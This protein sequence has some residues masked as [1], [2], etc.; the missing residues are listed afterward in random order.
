[1]LKKLLLALLL[2]AALLGAVV[3]LGGGWLLGS[4]TRA[5][6]PHLIDLAERTGLRVA[7]CEFAGTAVRPAARLSW[8]DWHIGLVRP[9]GGNRAAS[10]AT[11]RL[12]LGAVRLVCTDWAPLTAD[13]SVEG[14]VLETPFIPAAPADL[15]FA[16]DEFGVAIDRIDD[17]FLTIPEVVLG[18]DPR[19]ALAALA[20][21]LEQLAREG[22]TTRN[23]NLGARLHFQIGGRPLSVRLETARRSGATWLEFNAA[24]IAELS[25][26]H[27]RPLTAAEQRILCE[28]PQRALLLLR[29]KE[30]AERLAQRLARSDR[31]YGEDFTRHVVWSY[32]LTRTFGADFAQQVTDAHEAGAT[33]NTEAQH[34]QDF[35]NNTVGRSYALAKKSEGQVLRLI[36]T[37]PQIVRVAQ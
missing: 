1:V 30:Y 12:R 9:A 22:R 6:L 15:P 4:A 19:R 14:G 11:L 7:H 21:D 5:A 20:R 25:R 34:R 27:S 32:W 36:K 28:H 31:A 3:Y 26:R 35:A 23:L 24:D 29:I 13:L 8:I 16:G 33:D 17:G 37:D 18:T 2:F 10:A